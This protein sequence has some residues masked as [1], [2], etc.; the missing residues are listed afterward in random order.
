MLITMSFDS[1]MFFFSYVILYSISETPRKL[2]KFYFKHHLEF[3]SK[4]SLR[5]ALISE[6]APIR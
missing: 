6:I 4:F 3:E 1:I 2:F 5:T